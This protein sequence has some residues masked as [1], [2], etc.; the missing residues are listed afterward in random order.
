MLLS[1]FFLAAR[2]VMRSIYSYKSSPL[3]GLGGQDKN[4]FAVAIDLVCSECCICCGT[5]RDH[6]LQAY[7]ITF[8]PM[9][10]MM[11]QANTYEHQISCFFWLI[12]SDLH[13]PRF[14]H[15]S[16]MVASVQPIMQC[17]NQQTSPA[18]LLWLEKNSHK[19]KF[20]VR[21]KCHNGKVQLLVS[22]LSCF[23]ELYLDQVGMKFANV[24]P[25]TILVS[26]RAF[27]QRSLQ[28]HFLLTL[29]R[30]CYKLNGQKK[31]FHMNIKLRGPFR[32]KIDPNFARMAAC[33]SSSE[34]AYYSLGI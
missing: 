33:T 9:V 17:T 5:P 21:L 32:H 34:E 24:T 22:S 10:N 28:A 12:H 8:V 19:A 30:N 11:H 13:E 16:T 3:S 31:F 7:S 20:H 4:R 29:N 26:T 1:F 23:E 25:L 14:I 15:V 27:C 2:I 18:N 6:Q